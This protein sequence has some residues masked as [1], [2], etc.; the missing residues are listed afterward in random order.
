MKKNFQ[1]ALVCAGIGIVAASTS[2]SSTYD[3]TP[4]IPGRDTIKNALRGNFTAT[5]DGVEFVANTKYANDQTVGGVRTITISGVM[6]SQSKDP[7][8]NTT[9]S[10]SITNYQGPKTYPIQFGTAGT[11]IVQKN[12]VYTT[13]LA[14]TG[15]TLALV[16]ITK[17]QGDLEGTFN[18][19]VAPGGMGTANNHNVT[20]GTFSVPK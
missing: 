6:D 17:D 7:K 5:I 9:I 12:G 14:K 16:N 8:T 1:L 13:F 11:Y 4:S 20:N 10:L 18:F 3:A 19:V 15:D 2:C